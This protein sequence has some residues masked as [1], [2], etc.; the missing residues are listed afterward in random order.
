MTSRGRY[1]VVHHLEENIVNPVVIWILRS[2]VH[3]LLSRWLLVLT[4]RG[5][6]SGRE[7]ST[8]VLYWRRNTNVFLLTPKRQTN[9]WKN[10]RG[11]HPLSMRYRGR[12]VSGIGEVKTDEKTVL[13]SLEWISTPLRVLDEFVPGGKRVDESALQARVNEFAVI[14]ATFGSAS[15]G[16]LDGAVTR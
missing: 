11:G 14:H 2:P 7:F 10:F 9:W 3:F 13:E 12:E 15:E 5:R 1:A 16:Q 6:R 8:P 4:Y